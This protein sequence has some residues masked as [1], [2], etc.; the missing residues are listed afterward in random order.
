MAEKTLEPVA[1]APAQ[2]GAEAAAGAHT[3]RRNRLTM[4]EVLAQSVANAAPTA[5]MALLPLLVFVSAGN[6]T[7]LSFLIA[8]LLMLCV[9]FCAAQFARRMNSAGS[10]YV[11]VARGLGPLGGH[12]AGWGLQL[13]YVATAV[14]TILGFAIFGN[15]FLSYFGVPANSR[16]VLG[17][18]MVVDLVV[19]TAVATLDMGI[20]ARTSLI[21]EGISICIILFLCVSIWVHKGTVLSM[22]QFTLTGVTPGGVLVGVVLS[23]FAFVGFESAGSLGLEA[24]NPYRA[25]GRAIMLSCVVVGV[26]YLIVSYSQV[27]G[28]AGTKPGFAAATAPLPQLAQ[29][30]GLRPLAPIISLGIVCS[31]FA[32]TLACINA[33]GRIA[34][35]MAH[36]GLGVAAMQR[37][38]RTRHT[39][40]IALIAVAVLAFVVAI[41]SDLGGVNL[42]NLTGWVGSVAAFGFMLA[43]ILVCIAAP[44]WLARQ[45]HPWIVSAVVGVIGGVVMVIV[46]WSSWLPQLIPG[47][48]FPA[49]TGVAVWLPYVF[50]A[51]MAIGVVWYVAYRLINPEKAKQIGARFES[52]T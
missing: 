13:G 3:L 42:I 50:F 43:Y 52:N 33:A 27:Y 51:W 40:H 8:I 7:W 45:G 30:V 31:M 44:I 23:I 11:W 38:H 37:T 32:C 5:A 41:I 26:F 6:G 28:F 22:P 48:L 29:I 19:P 34:F 4:P 35:A 15:D 49:L 14:A 1:G 17:I 16:W 46:F 47:G 39:P 12:L 24:K 25:I 10:F 20:S 21:L 36:D 9:G 2:D 18:L